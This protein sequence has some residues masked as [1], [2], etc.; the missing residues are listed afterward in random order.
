MKFVGI[1]RKLTILNILF[2]S[3]VLFAE[4]QET[5]TLK[6]LKKNDRISV[7]QA[8]IYGSFVQRLGANSI[9]FPQ[10]IRI[11]NITTTEVFSFRVKPTLKSGKENTFCFFAK[12]GTYMILD[13][14][15]TDNKWY[16]GNSIIEPVYKGIDATDSLREKIDTNRINQRDLKRF[17]FTITN[18]SLNYLGTW[19]F[20]T[21]MIYF[22]NEKIQ[23]DEKL[24]RKYKQLDFTKAKSVI[25]E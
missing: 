6:E 18:N 3:I 14:W 15:W 24:K 25:P 19:H 23:L 2:L 11:V 20:D 7:D 9:G 17:T 16:G 22:S 13:Y 21:G 10:D 12:P 1:T 8:I 5:S 4:G